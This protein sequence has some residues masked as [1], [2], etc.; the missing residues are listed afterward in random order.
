ML[1]Y[2]LIAAVRPFSEDTGWDPTLVTRTFLAAFRCGRYRCDHDVPAYEGVLMDESNRKPPSAWGFRI[3]T[4]IIG[5]LL[6]V[7]AWY[8]IPAL[9]QVVSPGLDRLFSQR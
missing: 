1:Y 2:A 3:A 8:G 6:V 5:L 4:V 7:V 9:A